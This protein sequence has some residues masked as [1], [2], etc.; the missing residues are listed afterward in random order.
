MMKYNEMEMR[1]VYGETLNELIADNSNVICL[2]ADLSKASGTN[3]RV[4]E[5][6]PR[7]FINVGV[8]E[9]NMIGL[10]AG[11]SLEGKIPFCASFFTVHF[12][13]SQVSSRKA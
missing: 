5:K 13:G 8:A 9:A 1:A 7:N 10:A 3:P 6:N 4:S 2:E 12:L 11:L